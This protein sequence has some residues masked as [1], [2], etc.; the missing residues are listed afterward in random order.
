MTFSTAFQADAFQNDAFQISETPASRITSAGGWNKDWA[1]VYGPERHQWIVKPKRGKVRK[2]STALEAFD[3]I[4]GYSDASVQYAGLDF[5]AEFAR[6]A[7]RIAKENSGA[8][9]R[10]EIAAHMAAVELRARREAEE[11]DD[12]EAILLLLH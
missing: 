7:K 2:L 8:N 3:A 5:G 12:E 1:K 6:I 10:R 4:Q 9:I 11:R